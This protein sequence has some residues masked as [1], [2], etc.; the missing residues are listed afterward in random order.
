[1]PHKGTAE[2]SDPRIKVCPSIKITIVQKYSVH[3]DVKK[4][5]DDQNHT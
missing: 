5:T 2:D 1:M 4:T 3:G